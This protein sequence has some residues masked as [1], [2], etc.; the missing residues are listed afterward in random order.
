MVDA[1]HLFASL[2]EQGL[3]QERI[4]FVD[5]ASVDGSRQAA[6]DGHVGT[7]PWLGSD[8]GH[9]WM[10]IVVRFGSNDHPQSDQNGEQEHGEEQPFSSRCLA[11]GEVKV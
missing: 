7:E 1:A 10:I 11:L 5:N 4:V 6:A 8:R 2:L 3:S 9:D